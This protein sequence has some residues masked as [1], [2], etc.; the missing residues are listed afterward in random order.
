MAKDVITVYAH[1]FTLHTA[2]LMKAV[3]LFLRRVG[4]E[5]RGVKDKPGRMEKK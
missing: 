5:K 3:G 1:S 4:A 2:K